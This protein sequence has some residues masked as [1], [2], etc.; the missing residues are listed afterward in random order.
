MPTLHWAC[1]RNFINRACEP[2]VLDGHV[3]IW[4]NSDRDDDDM[5]NAP[6]EGPDQCSPLDDWMEVSS[7]SPEFDGI[8]EGD[9]TDDLL[10]TCEKELSFKKR[11]VAEKDFV[12]QVYEGDA[13]IAKA[14][15]KI[16]D[17]Q[18]RPRR[19]ANTKSTTPLATFHQELEEGIKMLEQCLLMDV[20]APQTMMKIQSRIDRVKASMVRNGRVEVLMLSRADKLDGVRKEGEILEKYAACY[21]AKIR[22]LHDC[23]LSNMVEIGGDEMDERQC[24]V[25][26]FSGHAVTEGGECMLELRVEGSTDEDLLSDE[27]FV[28]TAIGNFSRQHDELS[29]VLLNACNTRPLGLQ[30]QEHGVRAV[31]CTVNDI[32]DWEGLSYA[33][34]FWPAFFS[35]KSILFAHQ[36]ALDKLPIER[37]WDFQLLTSGMHKSEHGFL[38]ELP[39]TKLKWLAESKGI[40]CQGREK[41]ELV[42]ELLSIAEGDKGEGALIS[43]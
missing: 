8:L 6:S 11:G 24:D 33:K 32:P 21:N 41:T 7:S 23:S 13:T 39:T 15:R 14:Q 1:G 29:L 18:K 19:G 42:N 4:P 35:T 28:A 25:L 5:D 16:N 38:N 30:L 9:T 34:T 2:K 12:R 37:D 43:A 3:M 27:K 40:T 17:D 20:P 22:L 10:E 26:V 36:S 31:I